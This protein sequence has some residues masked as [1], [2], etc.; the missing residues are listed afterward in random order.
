M[1]FTHLPLLAL[2]GLFLCTCGS[3]PEN[4]SNAD[5]EMRAHAN[6]LAQKYLITDGHV[7]LPYRLKVRNFKL[8][9]EYL[10]IPIETDA[11][12]FDYVRAKE[13]GLD[14][15]F[16][17]IYIPSRL[18]E[19][20]GE[21]PKLA[22]SLITMVKG[23]ADAHPDKFR[24]TYTP[25]EMVANFEAGIVSLPMGMENGSPIEDKIERVKEYKDKGISYITLT[26]AKDNLICDSSYD[27]TAT[28]GGLSDFGRDVVK[29]MNR[30][31]IMVDISHV[32]DKT[33]WQVVEMTDVP[34]I[35]SHSSVRHFTP[36]FERNMD[37][38][39][40]K[41]LGEEGGIIQINFGSTF[42]DGALRTRQDSLRGVFMERLAAKDMKYGDEGTDEMQEAFEKEF[43]T[44]YSDLE[45]VADHIDR[46]VKLAGIDHVGLGSDF[47]GVGDSL[48]TGLK[49]VSDFP[50][51]IYTLL[52]RGYADEDIEKICSGNVIR[53]WKAVEAAAKAK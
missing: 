17:S 21:S 34:M 42:L 45:M 53:V 33:F 49:D 25:D 38:E 32:S 46:V 20:P 30:V 29:E 5:A 15:P 14:A 50:N 11:G 23:I 22:D 13:G 12:D 7:D 4:T 19:E 28:H 31:G 9:K 37:D 18:Q 2:L 41:R 35:A 8:D 39:M 3:A 47:D 10:G 27:T 36:G 52:K 48:P 6:E 51:L 16:M 1:K 44:L 26:H 43:P 24:V 40:I